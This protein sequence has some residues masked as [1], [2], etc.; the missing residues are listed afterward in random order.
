MW[1]LVCELV[2]EHALDLPCHRGLCGLRVQRSHSMTRRAENVRAC[3]Q[4]ASKFTLV[5]IDSPR[6]ALFRSVRLY[7]DLGRHTSS[8]T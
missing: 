5:R 4:S 7:I 6:K 3:T 1:L 2:C 8:H